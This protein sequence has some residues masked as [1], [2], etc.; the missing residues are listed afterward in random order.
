MA[1]NFRQ[2]LC[3]LLLLVTWVAAA[4]MPSRAVEPSGMIAVVSDIHFNPFTTR[5]LAAQ[6]ASSEVMEW[7]AIF[8]SASGQGISGRGEDTNQALFVSAL[9]ALSTRAGSADL[10]VVSGD[11]LAHRFEDLAAQGLGASSDSSTVRSLAAKTALY[12]ADALRSVLPARPILIALGNNDF[13]CGDYQIEPGG[14][15]LTS[16]SDIVRDLA[17]SDRVAWDFDQTFHAGGY[18]AMHHPTL[19]DV[20]ILVINDVLWS[21]EYQDT[22]GT[23]GT[24]AAEA[25]MAWLERRLGDARAAGRRIGSCTTFRLA[26]IP[27]RR[28]KRPPG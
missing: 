28:F 10:V 9:G 11:L 8:A 15:F 12:V 17:G 7:P 21:T 22:C 25:M 6:L 16:M 18:Y 20:T 13:E 5:D 3:G 4:S 14:T 27:M 19:A 26:S 23:D 2:T 24:A 1:H